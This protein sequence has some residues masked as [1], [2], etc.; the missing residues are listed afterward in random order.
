MR[1]RLAAVA[2]ALL[3]ALVV[4]APAAARPYGFL[5]TPTDQLAVPGEVAGF[6]VT[7][8]GFVYGGYG[9]LVF[10][11][12][13]RLV[14]L[15]APVRTLEGGRYPV[16]RYGQRFGGARYDL[17]V[18]ASE[19]AGQPVAFVRVTLRNTSAR[20]LR[21]RWAVGVRYSGGALKANGVRRFRYPRPV[22]PER[23]GLITQPGIAFA[24][25][26]DYGF[27]DGTLVRDGQVLATVAA[28]PAGAEVELQR[29][30]GAGA[31]TPSTAFD[32]VEYAVPLAP[33]ER[34]VLDFRMPS[35]PVPDGSP[36][37]VALRTASHIV[38][39]T[40]LLRTWRATFDRAMSLQ[41]PERRVQEA[42]YAS[43]MHILLPRYKLADGTWVQ[44]VNKLRYHAFWLR[45]AAIM[46]QALDLAG[47]HAE[48]RE[49]LEFFADWQSESGQFISREGQLDGH[50]QALWA[51]A[52]H[53]LRTGDGTFARAML[54]RLDRAVAWLHGARLADPLGIV[55][56]SDP[57]DNELVAGHL[58]GDDF[59]AVAG[60]A[61]IAEAARMLG[62]EERA[63]RWGLERDALAAAVRARVSAAA[64]R[65]GG[66]I[67]S[68]LDHSG[69]RDWGNLWA[70]WPAPVFDPSS[71]IVTATLT[72][73]RHDFREGLATYGE[74]HNL[75]HY[76]GFRVFQTEL[77]RDEQG[78]VVQ[79]LYDSLA[80]TTATYGGFETGVRPYARR[81]VDD[82][83]APHGWFA[84]ELVALVRNMLVRERDGGIELLSAVP[85]RWLAPGRATIVRDAP[86]KYGAVDVSLR[87]VRGGAVLR[88]DAG[89][90]PAGTPLWWRVPAGA[91]DVRVAT[92]ALPLAAGALRLPGRAGELRIAWRLPRRTPSFDGVTAALQKAYRD[93]GAVPPA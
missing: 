11:A 56:E 16:L 57:R 53:I 41:L 69:G 15:R 20:A 68:V 87:P 14:G 29:R 40:A 51:I 47:L 22:V 18:F 48:A 21:A 64:A 32:L 35:A 34:R 77:L 67:P 3:T 46:T 10:R 30:E 65:N 76:L 50:G 52:E 9:E 28:A 58:A 66:A 44:P 7:P 89:G 49:N 1:P 91:R 71:P 81:S 13:P 39:R 74:F 25:G 19:V 2:V 92:L 72:R 27:G 78:R 70:A 73:A 37:A 79:G 36:A 82:N 84:A 5:A 75:H 55:P 24:L 8:E 17:D 26:W 43:L 6:E 31:V 86:T 63:A 61:A 85:G 4:A 90:G 45:D 83:L 60:L 80:H 23:P 54:P 88:W 59:W 93:R 62:E 33:G 12:G 42:Y 38:Q